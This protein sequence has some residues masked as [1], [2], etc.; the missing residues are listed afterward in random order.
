MPNY[1]V[2]IP[3][4]FID[5]EADNEEDAVENALFEA[6]ATATLA[7]EDDDDED[8]D[9]DEDDDEIAAKA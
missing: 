4:Q 7:D 5:T 1:T 8:E 9:D 3:D 2:H 6:D